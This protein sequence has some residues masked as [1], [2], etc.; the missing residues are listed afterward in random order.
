[1][2]SLRKVMKGWEIFGLFICCI[3]VFILSDTVRAKEGVN[4]VIKFNDWGP[5]GIGIGKL[6]SQAAEMIQKRTQGRIK[7][8]CYF[9]QSLLKYADTFSGVA[10]GIAD[11]SLYTFGATSGIHRLNVVVGLPFIKYDSMEE[12]VSIYNQLRREFPVLDEEFEKLGVKVLSWRFMPGTQL[13]TVKK[14]CVEPKDLA[15]LRVIGGQSL[16]NL[17]KA[18]GA[19]IVTLGPPDWY[20]SLE[21]GLVQ[22]QF[23][24][25]VAALEFK[26]LELFKYHTQFGWS[27]AGC[28][29]IGFIV[30]LNTWKK[31][32]PED[33]KIIIETYDWVNRES[34]K[35][36]IEKEKEAIETARKMGHEIIDLPKEKI[37]EWAKLAMPYHEQWKEECLKK[38]YSK[39]IIE[40]IYSRLLKLTSD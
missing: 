5:P 22:G 6:H 15:G 31:L 36:D 26:I 8:E 18:S 27:G 29:P 11:I 33:Q 37:S 7:V 9:S 16:E 28:Q 38:G 12:A 4:L 32:S 10:E 24:H 13:H 30:N 34:M 35:Y 25:W 23:V 39:Q 1:M 17:A 20:T 14:K 19:A 3:T 21:R 40:S 2:L